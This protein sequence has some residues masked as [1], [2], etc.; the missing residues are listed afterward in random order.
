VAPIYYKNT[1]AALLV[2]PV[3]HETSFDRMVQSH[4]EL[5]QIIGHVVKI[6]VIANKIDLP[7]RQVSHARRGIRE[8]DR[9]QPLRGLRKAGEGLEMLFG[10]LIEALVKDLGPAGLRP[11]CSQARKQSQKGH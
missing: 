3:V 1:Q 6:L 10:C 11:G 2:Y 8:L 4:G 9:V 7:G 5:C